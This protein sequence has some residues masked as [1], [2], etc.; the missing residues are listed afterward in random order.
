MKKHSSQRQTARARIDA[1]QTGVT[2]G[3]DIGD[4]Y[5]HVAVL[6]QSGELIWE[7]RIRTREVELRR[8]LGELPK[9]V[10]ALETGAHSRW[11]AAA[12]RQCGHEVIVANVRRVR[13]IYGGEVK[14]DQLD[15]EKLARLARADRKLL[16]PIEHRPEK[17]QADL[18]VIT[19]REALVKMRTEAINMVRG[20][21]KAAGARVAD[22]SAEAFTSRA[23][24][25]LPELLRN[26]LGLVLEQID[27]LNERIRE[28]DERIEHLA[29]TEY[30][31]TELLR[32]VAGV[33][34]LSALTFRLTI[35]RGE[36]FSRS[37]DVGCYV[38]LRPKR[39]QSGEQD[40]DLGITKAGNPRLRRTLVN[41]AHYILG[42]FG[43]DCDLRRWGL[44]LA[45]AGNRKGAKKR[46]IVA[47]ARK[48]AVLLH[49]L[50]VSGE[51]YEP[52][53]NSRRMAA[54]GATAA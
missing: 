20:V 52:L 5:I 4:T 33:G 49:R 3:L 13:L 6:N 1:Q 42:P 41:C 46:A 10:V 16:Y 2:V 21:V 50:L 47:V 45:R 25:V 48:L 11:I 43:P 18:A 22:C 44:E 34:T 38:G 53:R 12:A 35:G 37:R 40:P 28:Y 29:R 36:R 8:W 14:T 26:A 15:A 31:E 51:V 54:K 23:N 27:G 24:E 30:P 7:G 32:Q 17:E 39:D 19:A 9:S